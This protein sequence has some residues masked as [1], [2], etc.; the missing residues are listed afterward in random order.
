MDITPTQLIPGYGEHVCRLLNALADGV[1]LLSNFVVQLPKHPDQHNDTLEPL[2]DADGDPDD[3]P[4]DGFDAGDEVGD[5]A[6]EVVGDGSVRGDM[7]SG[8]WQQS[9]IVPS[10]DP[11]MWREE[12]NR[13][14]EKLL[15]A[16]SSTV[17][18]DNGWTS[19]LSVLQQ[20]QQKYQVETRQGTEGSSE[21][22]S[23]MQ[24]ELKKIQTVLAEQLNNTEH[25]ENVLKK[26][27]TFAQMSMHYA[28]YQKV[29]CKEIPYR[30]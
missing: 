3:I 20:Y 26:N 2:A 11:S 12:T 16:R 6:D 27:P 10:V 9:M 8:M 22:L 4:E 1:L 18:Q 5:G 7:D 13:M 15:T 19:H 29:P 25:F 17:L 14:M 21:S 28:E 24:G 30:W 23:Y